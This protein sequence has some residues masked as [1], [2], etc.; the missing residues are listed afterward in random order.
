L[1]A[2]IDER[3]SKL[4]QGIAELA[5]MA[6]SIPSKDIKQYDFKKVNLKVDGLRNELMKVITKRKLD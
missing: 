6:K 5:S 4:E 1:S 2:S 3:I